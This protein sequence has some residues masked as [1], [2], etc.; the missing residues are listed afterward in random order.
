M[1]TQKVWVGFDLGGTKMQAKVYDAGFKEIGGKRRKTKGS[2][3]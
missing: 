2:G 1:A 3:A